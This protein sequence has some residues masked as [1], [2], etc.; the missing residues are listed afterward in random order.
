M[1]TFSDRLQKKRQ[2]LLQ[3]YDAE[4][5]HALRVNL[6]RMRSRL[7]Q[8]SGKE[9]RQLRHDL[10]VLASATGAARDWDTLVLNARWLLTDKQFEQIAPCLERQ[11][12][13]AHDSVM[14]MLQSETWSST[15]KQWARQERQHRQLQ[16]KTAGQSQRGL[17]HVL[18]KLAMA[19]RE[20]LSRDDNKRWH[21]LRIA[22]KDLRYQ[23]DATPKKERSTRIRDMLDL[24]KELQVEL[25]EWHDTVVHDQLLRSIESGDDDS[26]QAP[27]PDALHTL[28]EAIERRGRAH[29]D[30][31][32]SRLGEARVLALLTPTTDRV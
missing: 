2:S 31:A 4:D 8:I 7:K 16:K 14:Q 1:K 9:A 11:Q 10:G 18:E 32:D 30:Q 25:G 12:Q 24:C 23:L 27:P 5:L 28:R 22:I 20:T 6:R 26:G 15:M 21:K 3:V 29:L 17:S 13:T 19:R